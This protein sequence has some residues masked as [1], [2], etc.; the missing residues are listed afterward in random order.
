MTGK[1]I[2][3]EFFEQL[4][5]KIGAEE[6]LVDIVSEVLNLS[7]NAAYKRIKGMTSLHMDDLVI[8]TNHFGVSLDQLI[9][10]RKANVL[11][12]FRNLEGIPTSYS[13]YLEPMVGLSKAANRIPSELIKMYYATNELP[14][15]YYFP[16][17]A[18][19]YFKYYNWAWSNWELELIKDK[20][21]SLNKP[22]N[23]QDQFSTITDFLSE[24]YYK[25][26]SIDFLSRT[27]LYNT[28]Q[29]IK[30]FQSID[31]YENNDAPFEVCEALRQ[32]LKHT[33]HM[34]EH[35]KKFKPGETPSDDQPNYFLFHNEIVQSNNV[36][37][38]T[39]PFGNHTFVTLDNPNILYTQNPLMNDYVLKWIEKLKKGSVSLSKSSEKS[40][41]Q[42]F[43]SLF[44]EIEKTEEE[45]N[46][47]IRKR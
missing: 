8:L 3:L 44:N 1:R 36:S 12:Q 38:L 24:A 7:Q 21:L 28:T 4:K 45:L 5:L 23:P 37:V 6:N 43:K 31:Q 26:D 13:N 27:A 14:I 9:L 32:V 25:V 22:L 40:R 29:Q 10:N 11:F 42:F 41:I 19:N 16:F 35:G 47:M 18:I 17:R 33:M 39:T 30:Y 34:A 2:Q 46:L 15:Y 20:K